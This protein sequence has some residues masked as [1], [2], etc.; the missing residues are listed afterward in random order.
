MSPTITMNL[1]RDL[2]PPEFA[3][4]PIIES[5]GEETLDRGIGDSRI[6]RY[7]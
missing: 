4:E 7:L 3:P 6:E 5:D 2:P 1:L